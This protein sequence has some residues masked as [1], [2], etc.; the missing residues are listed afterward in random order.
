MPTGP[1]VFRVNCKMHL[2]ILRYKGK[3]NVIKQAGAG[4]DFFWGKWNKSWII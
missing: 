2:C 4:N 1:K 3:Q